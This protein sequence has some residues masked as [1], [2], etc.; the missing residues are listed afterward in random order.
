MWTNELSHVKI[1]IYK[2]LIDKS[3]VYLIYVYKQ[4]L[5]LINL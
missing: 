3:Y 5:A 2:L 4:D 1:V